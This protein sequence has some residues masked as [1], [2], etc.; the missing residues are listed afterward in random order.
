MTE[1]LTGSPATVKDITC[2]YILGYF[3]AK[4]KRKDFDKEKALALV[5]AY[6]KDIES[7]TKRAT[8]TARFKRAFAAE[9]FPHLI[10][11]QKG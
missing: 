6:E 9:Y 2:D 5:S 11:K 10:K 1:A 7:G 3:K 4:R 8:A